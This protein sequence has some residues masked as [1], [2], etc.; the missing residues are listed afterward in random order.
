M[1]FRDRCRL[2]G[3]CVAVCPVG[4]HSITDG[5]VFERSLCTHHHGCVEV[6]PFGALDLSLKRMGPGDV[7]EV[8]NRDRG[9][10]Q[11]SG[12]GLTISGGEPLMQPRFTGALLKGARSR[13][14]HTAV[15]T[16]L[17]A[18]WDTIS[19]M[20][21]LVDLWL[22]DVKTMDTETHKGL[23][24][25]ANTRI[26]E[27]LKRLTALRQTTVWIRVP[28]VDGLNTN[29]ENL[30]GTVKLIIDLRNVAAVELLP[31]HPLGEAKHLSLGKDRPERFSAP[32][33]ELLRD[34]ADR[35]RQVGAT[36]RY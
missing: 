31:Y 33:S 34:F 7:L 19:P 30:D 12:G 8:V 24:G 32:G 29:P 35:L 27:N 14:V 15:D 11:N 17:Y 26:L 16:C 25:V 2:C 9:Y 28:L 13:E 36:V 1:F 5:H 18:Q 21:P 22:V 10:Y 3:A 4:A 6:C 20:L 23:T